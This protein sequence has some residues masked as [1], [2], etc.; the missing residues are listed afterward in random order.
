MNLKRNIVLKLSLFGWL[1]GLKSKRN[2]V[3][4]VFPGV[5]V[6]NLLTSFLGYSQSIVTMFGIHSFLCFKFG[7]EGETG[8]IKFKCWSC[9]GALHKNRPRLICKI[10]KN[11]YTAAKLLTLTLSHD[12]KCLTWTLFHQAVPDIL[13]NTLCKIQ[14][15]VTYK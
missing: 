14:N 6:H 4:C 10:L 7:Q 3:K 9:R 11:V 8:Q 13:L 12:M 1:K 15:I 5:I 2:A